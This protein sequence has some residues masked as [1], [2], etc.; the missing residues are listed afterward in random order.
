[1]RTLC[2]R[3]GQCCL[4]PDWYTH[5][6]HDLVV[7]VHLSA[8]IVCAWVA[9]CGQREMCEPS[10]GRISH[11]SRTA[12]AALPRRGGGLLTFDL[13]VVL[14]HLLL[15]V[16]TFENSTACKSSC[17]FWP[18][19]GVRSG[20]GCWDKSIASLCVRATTSKRTNPCSRRDPRLHGS[21][22]DQSVAV[23]VVVAAQ[24][25][26]LKLTARRHRCR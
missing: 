8:K 1:M 22:S 19:H 26:R 12:R 17:W 14:W 6:R 24:L 18:C 21:S 2:Y 25:P 11:P 20:R 4:W 10:T 5:P 23:A 16:Q 15:D 13:E 9:N 7:R 3:S